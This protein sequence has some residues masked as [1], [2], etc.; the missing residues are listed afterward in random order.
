MNKNNALSHHF[1][2]IAQLIFVFLVPIFNT[3]CDNPITGMG[4]QPSYID[5]HEHKP[6]LNVFGVLRPDTLDGKPLSFVHLE[7]SVSATSFPD[8]MLVTDA[9][10]KVFEHDHNLVTDS[11][12]LDY[13]NLNSTFE[14]LEYR[15]IHFYPLPGLTYGISCVRDGYPELTS[16]TTIPLVPAIKENTL[17]LGADELSF[18]ILRDSLAALY[19]IYYVNGP[20]K[21]S[22]RIRPPAVGDISVKMD[23]EPGLTTEGYLIIYAYDAK[24]SEYMT[25]NVSIKPNTFRSNYSTVENGYGCFGSVNFLR[26]Y[27]SDTTLTRQE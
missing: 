22:Q 6:M 20:N 16:R 4:P 19:D 11:L 3:S 7:E 13:T 27:L 5:K 12:E 26:K 15:N 1:Q 2:K 8:N 21:Y 25:Y 14:T 10:I 17:F 9:K 18:I 24:L 23:F